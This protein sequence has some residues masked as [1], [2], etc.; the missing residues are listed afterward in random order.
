MRYAGVMPPRCL[1][2]Q[3]R[4]S[5]WRWHPP[6]GDR[7]STGGRHDHPCTEG[8]R[9]GRRRRAVPAVHTDGLDWNGPLCGIERAMEMK[10]YLEYV[11]DESKTST[12]ST[13]SRRHAGSRRNSDLDRTR[14]PLTRPPRRGRHVSPFALWPRAR[15]ACSPQPVA[16]S[17]NV[18]SGL[19]RDR[20]KVANLTAD[21]SRRAALVVAYMHPACAL[22]APCRAGAS[23]PSL[24]A[25]FRTGP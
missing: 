19:D 14:G 11:R 8:A 5:T 2:T 1:P 3:Q 24:T 10:A 20:N 17:P 7:S 23:A 12:P 25:L 9:G 15:Q 22:L 6:S 21:P 13:R 4:A 18:A 16:C